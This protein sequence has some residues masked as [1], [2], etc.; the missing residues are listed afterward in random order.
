MK[1]IV[2]LVFLLI[3]SEAFSVNLY[4]GYQTVARFRV[5]NLGMVEFGT[6]NQPVETCNSY[7][8]FFT[9]DP[10]TSKGQAMLSI[11]LA[12]K[13]SKSVIE[14]WYETSTAPGTNQGNGCNTSTMAKAY[15]IGLK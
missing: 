7:S 8:Y 12:A 9:F 1:F 4:S 13:M 14:V 15:S 11:L 5:N 10:S 6:N 2:G 3:T